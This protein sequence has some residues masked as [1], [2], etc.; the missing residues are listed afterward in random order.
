MPTDTI[1]I[2]YESGEVILNSHISE[3]DTIEISYLTESTD[4]LFLA[5]TQSN[6]FRPFSQGLIYDS[7]YYRMPVKLWEASY[8][9][10][11]AHAEF[12]YANGAQFDFSSQLP[13]PRSSLKFDSEI[14]LS[15]YLP[16]L[17]N[18]TI[19]EDFEREKTGFAL[20]LDHRYYLPA[21]LPT[22]YP[23]LSSYT[24]GKLFYRDMVHATTGTL[25]SFLTT[26]HNK[27]AAWENGN[28][29]GPYS[30]SDGYTLRKGAKELSRVQNSKSLVLEVL[31]E[32]GEAIS[33]VIGMDSKIFLAYTPAP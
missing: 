10:K 4:D 28:P 16:E 6:K 11:P 20:D 8:Y 14:I 33:T 12:I 13:R 19:I 32:P 15:L 31:L 2:N 23:A 9:D 18:I 5:F 22:I 25:E 21:S 30:T 17:R 1:L 29:I 7:F 3:T 27:R 24:E 26:T